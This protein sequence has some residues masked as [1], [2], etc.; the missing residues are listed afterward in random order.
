MYNSFS[1][2]VSIITFVVVSSS[3]LFITGNNRNIKEIKSNT[4]EINQKI[5]KSNELNKKQILALI[6]K[7]NENDHKIVADHNHINRKMNKVSLENKVRTENMD[8][9]IRSFKNITNANVVGLT[10]RFNTISK[11]ITQK[12]DVTKSSVDD[13]KIKSDT[14]FGEMKVSQSNL[15]E[16]VSS[17]NSDFYAFQSETDERL[18]RNDKNASDLYKD[19]INFIDTKFNAFISK[20]VK[21]DDQSKAVLDNIRDITSEKLNIFEKEYKSEDQKIRK[22]ITNNDNFYKK[23][24]MFN[25]DLDNQFNKLYFNDKPEMKNMN[26]L[27]AKTQINAKNIEEN[28]QYFT[29]NAKRIETIEQDFVKE[30]ELPQK[31]NRILPSTDIFKDVKQNANA[32]NQME[33]HVKT[34]VDSINR[35]NEELKLML[36]KVSGSG[37]GNLSLGELNDRMIENRKQ[38]QSDV[39]K[40]KIDIMNT[41]NTQNADIKKQISDKT[42]EIS[43]KISNDKD[44]Y[45]K[46]FDDY[47]S[48]ANLI[49]KIKNKNVDLGEI[50]SK[51]AI[52]ED[53]LVVNGVKFSSLAESKKKNPLAASYEK[54]FRAGAFIQPNKS[55]KLEDGLN[56]GMKQGNFDMYEGDFNMEKGKVNLTDSTFGWAASGNSVEFNNDGVLFNDTNVKFNKFENIQN[57]DGMKLGEF[58]D[59]KIK[60]GQSAEKMKEFM[61]INDIETK[62]LST[63]KLYIGKNEDKVEVKNELSKL[64][65]DLIGFATK[66]S[67]E[68]NNK[69]YNKDNKDQLY[70]DVRQDVKE[71]S[72]LYLPNNLENINQVKTNELITNKLNINASVNNLK[73]NNVNM[74]DE[75]DKRYSSKN[76]LD[77]RIKAL[78]KEKVVVKIGIDD[79]NNKILLTYKD[80]STDSVQLPDYVSKMRPSIANIAVDE[81]NNK[82][83]LSFTNGQ[84]ASLELPDPAKKIDLTPYA[85][86]EELEKT[87]AKKQ[88]KEKN[89]MYL[90]QEETARLS[91]IVENNDIVNLKKMNF[92]S[93]EKITEL[94]NQ[95][96]TNSTILQKLN[97]D[98]HVLSK[99]SLRNI[100]EHSQKNDSD[101]FIR[102]N[103]NV[104]LRAKGNRLQMCTDMNNEGPNDDNCHDLWTTKDFTEDDKIKIAQ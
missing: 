91:G 62:S 53:D 37:T 61:K 28:K 83:N 32:I 9:R 7:V 14:N 56:I 82:L 75:L 48:D 87:F 90:S 86:I 33:K 68:Q 20:D 41:M 31:M 47:I 89:L 50:K 58:V 60:S 57:K 59:D 102:L 19:S 40:N 92:P 8:A 17:L 65:E 15:E 71:N 54:D 25:Q 27:I 22:T 29:D 70:T 81:G 6:N 11:D 78:S 26:A 30:V 46:A 24:F 95:V 42:L 100:N 64:R 74:T 12:F 49:A 88:E 18:N 2:F 45:S 94:N 44:Q 10:D 85:R 35:N 51:T 97:N 63:P 80:E 1:F 16:Q 99:V 34:N 36:D 93:T 43:K 52:I 72:R 38:L 73:F 96:Q 3:T 55:L 67:V 104:S 77:E 21:M 66:N 4:S 5:I 13:Y 23:N 69:F 79:D 84:N 76:E 39:S 101:N 103:E 98:A